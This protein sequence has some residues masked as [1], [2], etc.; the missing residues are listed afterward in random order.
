LSPIDKQPELEDRIEDLPETDEVFVV[1]MENNRKS[2]GGYI[3]DAVMDSTI[4]SMSEE[5]T[6]ARVHGRFTTYF[7][8]VYKEFNKPTH[9]VQPFDIPSS[10]VRYRG[11]DFGFTNPFVCLWVAR[12]PDDEFYVYKEYYK[13]QTSIMT[14]IE[15]INDRST[16]ESFQGTY[17][18]PENSEDRSVMRKHGIPNLAAKKDVQRG[19]EK[20]QEKLKV[21]DNG[22]PSLY[23]FSTCKN[24]IGEFL[25]YSYP[26]GTKARNASDLPI[27][28]RDHAVSALRYVIYSLCHGKKK[29]R[30]IY[31]GSETA[32]ES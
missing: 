23:V 26:K 17:A 32:G 27:P 5:V 8:L 18:D 3:D 2:K 14:H 4:S 31:D 11:I 9:V 28:K 13:A 19:I 24:T 25:S 12:S 16:G 10:W 21:R 30:V 29:G 1:D 20:M 15:V 22:K 6:A 7:G